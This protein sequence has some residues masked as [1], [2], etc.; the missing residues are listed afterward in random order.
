MDAHQ[1][2]DI[3]EKEGLLSGAVKII[4]AANGAADLYAKGKKIIGDYYKPRIAQTKD[5]I[6]QLTTEK[7]AKEAL[8][9]IKDLIDLDNNLKE[10]AKE[11]YYVPFQP[12][13]SE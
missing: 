10:M 2:D 4:N 8:S 13:N 6:Y 12:L 9:K 5:K 1:Q 7:S 3:A 11:E